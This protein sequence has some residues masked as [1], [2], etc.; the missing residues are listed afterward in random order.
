M[1][2]SRH[3]I[4]SLLSERGMP[5]HIV[6]H[7]M[8]VRMVAVAIAHAMREAGHGVDLVL[9]D[10][11]SLLHDICKADSLARGGDHAGM[12]Q[13][14]LESLGYP[15]IGSIVGQ[16]IRLSSM[17]VNE[18]MVVNYAD[19]RVMHDRVVSLE[20]RF[21]D[22]MDRYSMGGQNMERIIAHFAHVVEIEE[23]V[24][25]A[26]RLEP[27]WLETLNLIPGDHPLYGGDRLLGE[28]SPVEEQDHDVDLERVDH[29]EPVDVDE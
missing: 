18:A 29:H 26:S 23:A 14:L 6:R 12:G 21:L 24:V 4:F 17:E 16:H 7:S 1:I 8:R 28:H 15:R 10:R 3:W 9:V 19:K 11:A 5:P 25:R 22:L 27:G 2:P 13:S 20:R